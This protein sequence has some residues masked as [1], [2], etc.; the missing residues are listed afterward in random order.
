[1]PGQLRFLFLSV[2]H[3]AA[4]RGPA[5][6]VTA[7]VPDRCAER[8]AILRV[9]FQHHHRG[10]T[11]SIARRKCAPERESR[12]TRKPQLE[13]LERRDMFSVASHWL[14]GGMLVVNADNA[15][16][17]VLVTQVGAN[18]RID[19]L[20]TIR[21]WDYQAAKVSGVEFHGG[22][23]NDRFVNNVARIA[24]S[25]WGNGG[26]DY[27]AGHN[28]GDELIGGDGND[29]LI[30][31]G[32]NDVLLGGRGNDTL[33]GLAGSDQLNGQ[34]G[35]DRLLGGN[36]NDVII[37]IDAAFSDYV[38]GGS[39]ADVIWT[40]RSG[41]SK[42]NVVGNRAVDSL[43]EVAS[44]ANGADLTLDG[45]RIVD[46]ATMGG[47]TYRAF[48][49]NPLFASAGPQMSDIQ[50]GAVGD[51]YMLAGLSAVARDNPHALRQNVVDFGDGT[52]GVRL[53]NSLYRVDNDL[54]VA[55]AASSRPAYAGFGAENSMWVAIVEKAFAHYR[56][57]ANSY[58][59]I[60]GGWGIEINRALGSK[61]A[62]DR[63]ISSYGSAAAMAAQIAG[64]AS[65]G[66]AVTIGFLGS[67]AGAG[68]PLVMNHMYTVASFARTAA[69][70]VASI[71][72]RN[73]WGV[74]GGNNKDGNPRDGLVTL[75]PTQIFAQLG[76]VNWGRV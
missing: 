42:D 45:D 68:A 34:G 43:Q 73:P 6:H 14:S 44:F 31:K 50:Q 52:Y 18:I 69:G 10:G 19:E 35:S 13:V 8:V 39:G 25:A 9:H 16:T 64:L 61:S 70:A 30:G 51:C 40:D 47:K 49:G 27:L 29:V 67:A 75:T 17:S 21:F 46:P 74:D 60:E 2:H 48:H 4:G 33:Q 63:S 72:L 5:R 59:S 66:Q 20:G 11:V 38:D 71:T 22:A 28:G 57:G 55:N 12:G 26:N 7:C 32:G 56:R 41:R 36:G 62:G 37:S 15:A 23:G 76:R 24:V 58:A 3:L 54:P 65:A 1:M 53:G